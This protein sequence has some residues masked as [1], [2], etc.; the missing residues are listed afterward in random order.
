MRYF[1]EDQDPA[2][3]QVT[4][5][6]HSTAC[7]NGAIRPAATGR[8]AA[9][10]DDAG[11]YTAARDTATGGDADHA[12]AGRSFAARDG[13]ADHA[14]TARTTAGHAT[15][16]ASVVFVQ[17]PGSSRAEG[18]ESFEATACSRGATYGTSLQAAR[19]L[20]AEGGI[21]RFFH[22][23][24]WRTVNITGT[25]YIASLCANHLPPYVLA[26]TRGG[27]NRRHA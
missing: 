27:D 16:A 11:R 21:G 10:R 1:A 18:D 14:A 6:Q 20:L 5:P 23:V 25:V 13:D 12:V 24:G 22:G 15:A 8:A 26:I 19:T 7:G 2:S 9:A 3:I 4:V 17:Y